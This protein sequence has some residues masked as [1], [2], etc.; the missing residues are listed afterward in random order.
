MLARQAAGL[1]KTII[2]PVNGAHN[3][4]H[5]HGPDL[6]DFFSKKIAKKAVAISARRTQETIADGRGQPS[7]SQTGEGDT[8][9]Q[10]RS[11][12]TKAFEAT[13]ARYT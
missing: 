1:M 9:R 5:I 2:R 11:A 7:M 4:I 3:S 10:A 13:P 8:A 6:S 12:A